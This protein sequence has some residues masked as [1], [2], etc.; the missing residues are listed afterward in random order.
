MFL[1][2]CFCLNDDA[3]IIITRVFD[4][5]NLINAVLTVKL[6]ILYLDCVSFS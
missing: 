3:L 6:F 4:L 2:I 5:I 1:I